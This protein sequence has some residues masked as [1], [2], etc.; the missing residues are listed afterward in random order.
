MFFMHVPCFLMCT[1]FSFSFIRLHV[2]A[3]AIRSM[4]HCGS[5]FEAG[6][7]GLPYYCT[8]IWARSCCTWRASFVDS[9]IKKKNK[10]SIGSNMTK[11][12]IMNF[13]V[14]HNWRKRYFFI[15]YFCDHC[16][17]GIFQIQISKMYICNDEFDWTWALKKVHNTS[18]WI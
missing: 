2:C 13:F 7:S 8:S 1:L 16:N 15:N 5:A 11:T 4:V 6:V 17:F 3:F 14:M 18:D 12:E 9:K 10:Q